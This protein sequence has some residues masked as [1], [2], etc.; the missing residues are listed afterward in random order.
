MYGIAMDNRGRRVLLRR[1]TQ[2]SSTLLLLGAI[3]TFHSNVDK[4]YL[5]GCIVNLVV[6]WVYHA[7]QEP[8]LVPPHQRKLT[9]LPSSDY[10]WPCSATNEDDTRH[11]YLRRI[12]QAAVCFICPWT[13]WRCAGYGGDWGMWSP[14]IVASISSVAGFL[15]MPV[16]GMVIAWALYLTVAH[17]DIRSVPQ[18]FMLAAIGGPVC[19]GYLSLIG[20]W[21]TPYRF[22][23]HFCCACLVGGGGILH[24]SIS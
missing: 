22:I 14:L 18:F 19:F 15:D 10:E 2:S 17:G 6:S 23:W 1:I 8:C 21:C 7:A 5:F 13:G 20:A 24:S 3:L 12:D 9:R 4:V 16:N 11:W